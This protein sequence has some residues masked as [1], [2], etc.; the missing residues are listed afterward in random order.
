MSP[1][2]V[3]PMAAEKRHP[4][5]SSPATN[6]E[7]STTSELRGRMVAARKEARKSPK[8]PYVAKFSILCYPKKNRMPEPIANRSMA[9]RV[10]LLSFNEKYLPKMIL[11]NRMRGK[12]KMSLPGTLRNKRSN[13]H[14]KSIIR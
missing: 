3:L 2:R 12:A 10:N 14:K 4:A 6:S 9:I 1:P 7:L 5:G 11:R 8:Y 13:V